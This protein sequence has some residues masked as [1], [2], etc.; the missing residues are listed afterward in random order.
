MQACK[1]PVCEGAGKVWPD[2]TLTEDT[3]K[4]ICHGCDGRGW[5][6]PD[7]FWPSVLSE[8]QRNKLVRETN[9]AECDGQVNE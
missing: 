5:I 2:P 8:R 7:S 3:V 6:N 9:T 4:T 1:C